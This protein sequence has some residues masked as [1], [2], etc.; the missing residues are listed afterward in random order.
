MLDNPFGFAADSSG[1]V[2]VAGLF[3]NN[4]FEIKLIQ[5]APGL[6]KPGLA[7][8]GASLVGTAWWLARRSRVAIA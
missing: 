8:L 2:Y 4:A 5:R 6:S 7:L 3:S 1:N